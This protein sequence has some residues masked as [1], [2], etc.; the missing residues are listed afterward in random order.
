[1]RTILLLPFLLAACGEPPTVACSSDIEEVY[2]ETA[3]RVPGFGGLFLGGR[4]TVHVF[5][6]SGE[7]KDAER[8]LALA[9]PCID[10]PIGEVRQIIPVTGDY[11]YRDLRAWRDT[12]VEALPDL[13][14]SIRTNSNR[15]HIAYMDRPDRARIES[16]VRQTDVPPDAVLVAG[17]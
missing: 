14:V 5:M 13:D 6:T 2:A 3:R 4:G 17:P 7:L 11:D 9:R 12:L 16:T 15:I 8:A 10:P 1:M